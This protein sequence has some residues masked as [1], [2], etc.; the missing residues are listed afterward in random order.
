MAHLMDS[1]RFLANDYLAK[2]DAELHQELI[3][4][5]DVYY[6]AIFAKYE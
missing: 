4:V 1:G 2:T 3:A 6:Q 5:S